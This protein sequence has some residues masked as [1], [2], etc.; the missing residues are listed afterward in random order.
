MKSDI[1]IDF[2]SMH[3]SLEDFSIFINSGSYEFMSLVK[4]A[5]IFPS[6]PTR[7]IESYK[8]TQKGGNK[9]KTLPLYNLNNTIND[10]IEEFES[11]ASD[12]YERILKSKSNKKTGGYNQKKRTIKN[13]KSKLIKKKFKTLKNKS[14]NSI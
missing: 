9:N 2:I 13:L 10:Y 5:F 4:I 3:L 11:P 14:N 6:K 1:L 7:E 8:I 12:H